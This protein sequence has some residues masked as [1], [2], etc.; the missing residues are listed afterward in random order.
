M[1]TNLQEAELYECLRHLPEYEEYLQ[2]VEIYLNLPSSDD[3]P[4]SYLWL[5]DVQAE[6]P[7]LE[8][9]CKGP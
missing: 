1:Y 2:T 7:E 5:K 8:E 6:D 9:L 4:L 3:N